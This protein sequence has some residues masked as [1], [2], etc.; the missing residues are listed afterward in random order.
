MSN[1]AVCTANLCPSS[2]YKATIA[3]S[4]LLYTVQVAIEIVELELFGW[5][6]LLEIRY[7]GLLNSFVNF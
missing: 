2:A 5:M 7:W 4:L 1:L 3:D 6:Y